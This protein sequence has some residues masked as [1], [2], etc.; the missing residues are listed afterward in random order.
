MPT[1]IATSWAASSVLGPRTGRDDDHVG[2]DP[3]GVG[4]DAHDPV[5]APGPAR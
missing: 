3:S 1:G 2:L 4:L 5:A